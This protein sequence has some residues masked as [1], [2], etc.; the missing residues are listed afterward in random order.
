[1]FQLLLCQK[2]KKKKKWHKVFRKLKLGFKRIIKWNK[3][4]SQMTVE[5]QNNYPSYL[6][7]PTFTKLIDYLFCH[8]Q[9]I[10]QVITEIFVHI[11]MYQTLKLKTLMF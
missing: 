7:D 8:L 6:I 4:R 3:Y 2:K 11:I 10:M 9:E 1:M 5:P